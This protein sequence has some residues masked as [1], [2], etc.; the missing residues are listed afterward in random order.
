MARKNDAILIYVCLIERKA[1]ED[2]FED[3][4]NESDEVYDEGQALNLEDD[5]GKHISFDAL[6]QLLT[7]LCRG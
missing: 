2:A 3:D 5:D 6:C 7:L 4:E 1:L